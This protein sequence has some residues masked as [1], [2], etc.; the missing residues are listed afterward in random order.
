MKTTVWTYRNKRVVLFEKDKFYFLKSK[1][2]LDSLIE[3]LLDIDAVSHNVEDTDSYPMVL[4]LKAG[5][6]PQLKKVSLKEYKKELVKASEKILK[7]L[8]K[9]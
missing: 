5:F 2:D 1:K 4:K 6:S 7:A 9:L 3:D 8:A